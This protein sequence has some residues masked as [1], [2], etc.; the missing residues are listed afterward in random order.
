MHP[1]PLF[2]PLS[3]FSFLLHNAST[4]HYLPTYICAIYMCNV[5]YIHKHGVFF[6]HSFALFR[7]FVSALC[8]ASYSLFERSLSLSSFLKRPTPPHFHGTESVATPFL[9]F[10]FFSRFQNFFVEKMWYDLFTF[11][12]CLFR[13]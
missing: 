4:K 6:F 1:F 10:L 2:I 7:F 12:M 9:N 5:R 11:C 3:S 8:V 13:Y